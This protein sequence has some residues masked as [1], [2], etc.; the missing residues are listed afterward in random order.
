MAGKKK[1]PEFRHP[2]TVAYLQGLTDEEAAEHPPVI[3][4]AGGVCME[5]WREGG[6]VR[7]REVGE[8]SR[9]GAPELEALLAAAGA[10]FGRSLPRMRAELRG[11]RIPDPALSRRRS[12]TACS[13]PGRGAARP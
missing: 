11:G 5:Y 3:R 9:V 8:P 4:K 13:A 7:C 6:R 2:N 1:D 12:A 10:A